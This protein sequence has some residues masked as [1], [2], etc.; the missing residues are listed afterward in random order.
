MGYP[1]FALQVQ[2]LAAPVPSETPQNGY[3]ACKA[4]TLR[5]PRGSKKKNKNGEIAVNFVDQ[6]GSGWVKMGLCGLE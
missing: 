4:W 2:L 3:P 5:V 6:N 1:T